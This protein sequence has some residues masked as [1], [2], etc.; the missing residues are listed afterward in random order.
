M[1]VTPSLSHCSNKYK[2]AR[3]G[4]KEKGKVFFFFFFNVN[5]NVTCANILKCLRKSHLKINNMAL[6]TANLFCMV[7]KG[8]SSLLILAFFS[9]LLVAGRS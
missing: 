5:G 7:E 3:E 2:L 9:A 4:E 1:L 8:F 6:L